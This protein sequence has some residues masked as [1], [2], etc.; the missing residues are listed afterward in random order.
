MSHL[1]ARLMHFFTSLTPLGAGTLIRVRG[2]APSACAVSREGGRSYR[3]V[4]SPCPA[5]EPTFPSQSLFYQEFAEDTQKFGSRLN[6][7]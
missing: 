3:G 7:S 4:E 6:L 2:P 1:I 5:R